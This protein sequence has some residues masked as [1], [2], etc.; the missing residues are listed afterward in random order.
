MDPVTIN[1]PIDSWKRIGR[2]IATSKDTSITQGLNDRGN[3]PTIIIFT[4][5]NSFNELTNS[6]FST[7]VDAD[8]TRWTLCFSGYSI[9]YNTFQVYVTNQDY[10]AYTETLDDTIILNGSS[11]TNTSPHTIS[12]PFNNI[13]NNNYINPNFKPINYVF[14]DTD[15]S[16]QTLNISSWDVLH[17]YLQIT[18]TPP[19]SFPIKV[20]SSSDFIQAKSLKVRQNGT[21]I[22]AK[23][24]YQYKSGAWV[25]L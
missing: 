4:I 6:N 1:I 24:I 7:F 20:K 21:W 12:I 22:D 16:G 23:G 25:K 17:P 13:K 14:V 10:N 3:S 11:G 9:N 8:I 19:E 15:T 2:N 18:Y 5:N